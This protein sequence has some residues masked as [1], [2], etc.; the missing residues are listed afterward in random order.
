M[1]L[2]TIKI[3]KE[4]C[5][6]YRIKNITPIKIC[7]INTSMKSIK[8]K[9]TRLDFVWFMICYE[10][11]LLFMQYR[12]SPAWVMI[13]LDLFWIDIAQL[14]SHWGPLATCCDGSFLHMVVTDI[15]SYIN[16]HYATQKSIRLVS[17]QCLQSNKTTTKK[18]KCDFVW[19]LSQLCGMSRLGLL[20]V[21]CLS[22]GSFRLL[23]H[24]P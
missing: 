23:R 15:E 2:T 1:T 9:V 7:M 3:K 8:A 18:I 5:R 14:L 22:C 12:I 19:V 24:Y 10:S 6:L 17:L 21:S 4:I 11:W 16:S 13:D 20:R